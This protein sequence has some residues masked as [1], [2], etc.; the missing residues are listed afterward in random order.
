MWRVESIR[1][2]RK[3]TRP[4]VVEAALASGIESGGGAVTSNRD[5]EFLQVSVVI[6]KF[7]QTM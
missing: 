6:A 4:Q 1:V 2:S 3:R 7:S 5:H